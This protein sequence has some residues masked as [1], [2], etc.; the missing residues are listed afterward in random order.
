MQT[1]SHNGHGDIAHEDGSCPACN[2]I[3]DMCGELELKQ[4]DNDD[5]TN[6]IQRLT[7]ENN[8]LKQ[9]N[10]ELTLKIQNLGG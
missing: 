1:C 7:D 8:A 4:A 10:H 5:L 3:E 9:L 2:R 6:D